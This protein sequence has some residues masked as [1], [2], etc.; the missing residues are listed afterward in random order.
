MDETSQLGLLRTFIEWEGIMMNFVPLRF[1]GVNVAKGILNADQE[2]WSVRTINIGNECVRVKTDTIFGHVEIQ[3]K[4]C[5]VSVVKVQNGETK[6]SKKQERERM[7]EMGGLH[8]RNES[9]QI[10]IDET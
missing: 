5:T 9:V 3:E 7:D 8:A 10:E 1:V 6:G 4:R 2:T